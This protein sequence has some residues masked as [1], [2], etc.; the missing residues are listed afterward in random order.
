MQHREFF[1]EGMNG[2][3]LYSQYWLPE[4]SPLLLLHLFM[5]LESIVA[6]T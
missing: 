5:E 1:F 2:T 3:Q 6:D 4:E